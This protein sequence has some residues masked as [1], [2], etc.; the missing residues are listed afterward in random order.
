MPQFD[1]FSFSSQIFWLFFF[2]LFTYSFLSY[3]LL[4][5]LAVSIK[6]RNRRLANCSSISFAENQSFSSNFELS[7][8]S[9]VKYLSVL[10]VENTSYNLLVTQI[11][12]WRVSITT[13]SFSFFYLLLENIPSTLYLTSFFFN[14]AFLV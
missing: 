2:L 12:I 7:K 11:S 9:L 10:L 8:K 3:Y 6:V 1:T 14:K 5:A 4:P 13:F